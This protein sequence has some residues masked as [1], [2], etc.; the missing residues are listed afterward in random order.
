MTLQAEGFS[1]SVARVL[2]ETDVDALYTAKPTSRRFELLVTND[3]LETHMIRNVRILAAPRPPDGRV[4]RD[5]ESFYPTRTLH[6]PIS[7]AS[8]QGDCLKQVLAMDE[9]EYL[10]PAD[11]DDL[12]ARETIELTFRRG[13]G[14]LGLVIAARNSL[15]NTFLF[16]QTLAYMGISAGDWIMQLERGGQKAAAMLRDA[17]RLLNEVSATVLTKEGTWVPAG[18]FDEVGPIA[19][20]VQVLRLPDNLSGEEVHLRL[21][22]TRGNWKLDYLALAELEA[23]VDPIPVAIAH[24]ERNGARDPEAYEKLRDQDA[25]LITYPKEAYT[26]VFNLPEGP[27]ELFLE[28]RGYYYEWIRKQWLPEEDAVEVARILL[29]PSEAFRRLA[30]MYKKIEGSM[31]KVFWQSRFG[32]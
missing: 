5:G 13:K 18:S 14:T 31:E 21:T 2:E 32:R 15:L 24:V 17:G 12:A 20:E 29:E 8:E 10:S 4:F 7:C 28:S 1:G 16:Y 25:Y 26:L 23:P 6:P 11:G 22:L 3:A 30:P 9:S 19:R 27:L